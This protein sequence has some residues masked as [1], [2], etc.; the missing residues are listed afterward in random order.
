MPSEPG[1]VSFVKQPT[2]HRVVEGT[3]TSAVRAYVKAQSESGQEANKEVPASCTLESDHVRGRVSAPRQ[4]VLP[5]YDQSTELPDR[6]VPPS[7]LVT[8][9]DADGRSG[10]ALL[11]ANPGQVVAGGS[12]NL[13]ADLIVLGASAAIAA[14]ANWRYDPAVAV[15]ME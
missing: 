5:K 10:A 14:S 15:V 1:S 7:I 2:T 3:S 12:G 9:R 13:V 4:V 8:C 11:A 6:G